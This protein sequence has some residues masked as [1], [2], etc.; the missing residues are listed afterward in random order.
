VIGYESAHYEDNMRSINAKP[1]VL[2]EKI[3]KKKG[4]AL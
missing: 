3:D 1:V 4:F 2:K